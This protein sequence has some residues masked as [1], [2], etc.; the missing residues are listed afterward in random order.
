MH[1][2]DANMSFKN[3]ASDEKKPTLASFGVFA[4]TVLTV[5]YLLRLCTRSRLFKSITG[6][7]EENARKRNPDLGDDQGLPTRTIIRQALTDMDIIVRPLVEYIVDSSKLGSVFKRWQTFPTLLRLALCCSVQT[8]LLSKS[9][10]KRDN[11]GVIFSA[12]AIASALSCWLRV[13]LRFLPYFLALS[14]LCIQ[15]CWFLTRLSDELA[16]KICIPLASL[17]TSLAILALNLKFNEDLVKDP[18][19][20]FWCAAREFVMQNL[21]KLAFVAIPVGIPITLVSAPWSYQPDWKLW[22]ILLT[23]NLIVIVS[24]WLYHHLLRIRFGNR[25]S[26]LFYKSFYRC[27][28]FAGIPAS[29]LWTYNPT[30]PRYIPLSTTASILYILGTISFMG[31]RFL[32]PCPYGVLYAVAVMF[33]LAIM[34]LPWLLIYHG[35]IHTINTSWSPGPK[36][37]LTCLL[38]FV[39]FVILSLT[40]LAAR[41]LKRM[42]DSRPNQNVL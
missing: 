42:R 36:I 3:W 18:K 14:M 27:A 26:P 31:C 12:L 10:S 6:R 38:T 9:V 37:Y 33:Y 7:I 30:W 13:S 41:G 21:S 24:A 20:T 34:L 15:V 25:H 2:A 32:G 1:G 23:D 40:I 4:A 5:S 11:P 29:L 39:E 17:V 16:A 22:Q 8:G 28:I 19:S 35:E